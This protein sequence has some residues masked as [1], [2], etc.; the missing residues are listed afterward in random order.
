MQMLIIQEFQISAGF[1]RY[2]PSY[3]DSKHGGHKWTAWVKVLKT[4]LVSHP[5]F[6]FYS[7]FMLHLLLGFILFLVMHYTPSREKPAFHRSQATNL[8]LFSSP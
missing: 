6:V 4:R 7:P 1:K 5:R 2:E 3:R 8:N